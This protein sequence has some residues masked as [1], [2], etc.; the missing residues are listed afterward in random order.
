MGKINGI[1]DDL[2]RS[3]SRYNASAD[4]TWKKFCVVIAESVNKSYE[5]PKN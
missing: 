5:P 2:S 3:D 1:S 4:K